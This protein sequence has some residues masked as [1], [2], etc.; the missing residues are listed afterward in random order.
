MRRILR[1][2]VHNW[3]LK[4]A[5][6]GLATLMYGGLALSQNTQTYPGEVPVRVVNQPPNTVAAGQSQ[7][8]D[9]D[10]LLR[11]ERRAGGGQLVRGDHR[12]RRCRPEGR[13][14]HASRSTSKPSTRGSACSATTRPFASIQLEPLTSKSVPVKVE[15]GV[16]PDGLTLGE[17]VVDPQNV[18]V[19]GAGIG[20]REG[21]RG[22]GRRRSSSRRAST[23]TRTSSSSR[24]TS[25]ATRSA[26][27]RSRRRRP[28]SSSRSSPT[29][30]AG[31]CRSTRSS[32]ARRPPASRSSR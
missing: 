15:H 22:P 16:V 5:A 30:R 7:A 31:R 4:L 29:A 14:G 2:I 12:P 11:A 28:A 19:S 32:P 26:R 18:T 6:V 25:S 21:R 10:P 20:R 17:T 3:P 1:R 8:G 9:V 13:P 24:S 23:S 27:S